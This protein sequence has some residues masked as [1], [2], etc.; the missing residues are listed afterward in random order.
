MDGNRWEQIEQLID[1][2]MDLPPDERLDFLKK[3]ATD[4]ELFTEASK[5]M[6]YIDQ[7]DEKLFMEPGSLDKIE[8]LQNLY[9]ESL[10]SEKK[11]IGTKLGNFV[12][13][14]VLG[15][16][17]MATVFKGERS[18]KTINQSVAIKILHSSL[19][20]QESLIRF[21]MEQEILANLNHPN[22]AHFVD[23][24]VTEDDNPY[25]IMEYI[26]G[27]SLEEY[28]KEKA[29]SE[30]EKLQLFKQLCGAVSYA[31]RHLV[32]HRDLKPNNVFVNKEGQ[33]KVLDFSIA[34]L[35][36]P[37]FSDRTM[38]QTRAGTKLLSPTY[39]APEQFQMDP[40]T[41]ATDVYTLG[42][43]LYE[44]LTGKK[45]VEGSSKTL[46]EVEKTICKSE[47]KDTLAFNIDSELKAIIL[48]ATRK[49]P[50]YRYESAGQFLEDLN[51]Y[52]DSLPLIAQK[53]SFKYRISKFSKRHSKALAITTSIFILFVSTGFIYTQ[54]IEQERDKA[55]LE[56]DRANRTTNFLVSIF[57]SASIENY[58]K[59]PTAEELLENGSKTAL[60]STNLPAETKEYLLRKFAR[61]YFELDLF[62][63]AD[64]L[65]S[66]SLD[67]C[68]QTHNKNSSLMANCYFE[69]G[70]IQMGLKNY[71]KAQNYLS[72]SSNIIKTD[73]DQWNLLSKN[74][75]ELGWLNYTL[76]NYTLS[77][78]LISKSHKI[79]NRNLEE[80]HEDLGKLYLYKAWVKNSLGNYIE[81]DSL[82]KRSIL[83][84]EKHRPNRDYLLVRALTGRGRNFYDMGNSGKADSVL[85]ISLPLNKKIYGEPSSEYGDALK[86]M[87]LIKSQLQDYENAKTYFD[88][89]LANYKNSV[90]EHTNSYNTALNDLAIVHFRLGDH[91]EAIGSFKQLIAS[92][93]KILGPNH[94]EIATGLSN[95]ATILDL[96]GQTEVSIPYFEQA[97]QIAEQNYSS[98]HPNLLR[99]KTNA[100]K[101]L[102]KVND[103][104][105]AENIVIGSIAAV[106]DSGLKN[107]DYQQLLSV[108]VLLYE[109]WG[110]DDLA[111]KYDSLLSNY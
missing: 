23:A 78:S 42:L 57:R 50:E 80:D 1:Q 89:A 53:D 84:F 109:A 2:A 3:N 20:S 17:G 43:V 31:H 47:F 68:E 15:R 69:Y 55:A 41:T 83:I 61:I 64:T 58:S 95:L 10:N 63:K 85:N 38:V 48:K 92:N 96:T 65:I 59:N 51:R 103:Y 13:K 36:D 100:S 102:I 99:F 88:Q 30:H 101:A 19:H 93:K 5:L 7:A 44:V 37:D 45:A 35:L 98:T 25:F 49:E 77:D 106:N 4:K 52:E 56:A 87:G 33:V 90:G 94:P 97:I 62:D 108:A 70:S 104:E 71:D 32:V 39:C 27:V 54:Q 34:K 107:N 81:A 111:A 105:S 29:P 40:I 72:L 9:D 21:R 28:C 67:L 18:D 91:E 79:L 6:S 73:P 82:F 86:V 46:K 14:G 75:S 24:G 74:Y 11:L 26:D 60:E 12:I 110:K 16:G 76:G 22:I 66:K 8:F